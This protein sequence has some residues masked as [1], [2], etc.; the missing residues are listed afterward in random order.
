MSHPRSEALL[1]LALGLSDAAAASHVRGCGPCSTSRRRLDEEQAVLRAHYSTVERRPDLEE[2]IMSSLPKPATSRAQAA[3]RRTARATATE[4]FHAT[5]G[6]A[7]SPVKVLVGAIAAVFLVVVGII[8][9]SPRV[10]D[11]VTAYHVEQALKEASVAD[12][13]GNFDLAQAK[14]EEA[15]RLMGGDDKWRTRSI[16]VRAWIKD[17]RDRRADLAKAE[18]EFKALKS[19]AAACRDEQAGG[20]LVR[21]CAMRERHR[22]VPWTSE[23]DAILEKL[24]KSDE[25]FR[26]TAGRSAF[27]VRRAEILEKFKL[28]D[29]KAAHWSGAI[30]AWKE[31]LAEK[32]TDVDRTKAEKEIKVIQSLAREEVDSIGKR[33]ARMVEEGSKADA[34]AL[35][36]SQRGRFELTESAPTLEKL[37]AQVDR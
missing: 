7:G 3:T 33:A 28:D 17:V 14:Y 37:I 24:R 20:L 22:A 27:Q 31:Y 12:D 23:L 2:M 30:R 13:A 34:V 21:A 16:E 1:D 36:K 25:R 29:R 9:L 15:L 5:S 11:D 26:E 4:R 19:E 35:L 32:I 8:V 10:D 18:G 6:K